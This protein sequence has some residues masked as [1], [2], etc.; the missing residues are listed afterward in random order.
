MSKSERKQRNE[1]W[2]DGTAYNTLQLFS[3]ASLFNIY[4]L[5]QA[6]NESLEFCNC[7]EP[8]EQQK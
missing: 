3:R 7:S 1:G 6:L 8:H 5:K 2:I 4:I